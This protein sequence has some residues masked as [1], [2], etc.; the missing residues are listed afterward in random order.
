MDQ[1]DFEKIAAQLR[2][3]TGEE[4]IKTAIRMSE[5]NAYMIEACIDSLDLKAEN[6]VLEMGPGGGLHLPYL[7]KKEPSLQYS[8]ID[9]SETMIEMAWEN[10]SEQV[11]NGAAQFTLVNVQNGFCKVPF[12]DH[13]FDH[14]FTVNTLYFWDDALAQAKE[15]HRVLK[16]AAQI[17]IAFAE[18]EFMEQLP[19]TKYD[20]RLYHKEEVVE[21]FERAGFK[22]INIRIHT[23]TITNTVNGTIERAFVNLTAEK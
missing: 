10:N 22:N 21:L 8:G 6:K 16:P 17:S 18:A 15:L 1:P 23:E 13:C 2:N 11:Q 3:P 7:F 19:F 4:G 12:G 14:I 9:I 5:N 20:F